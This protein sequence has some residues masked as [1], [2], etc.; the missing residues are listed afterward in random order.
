MQI[1]KI[2]NNTEIHPIVSCQGTVDTNKHLLWHRGCLNG[3]FT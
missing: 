2:V 3:K 1:D